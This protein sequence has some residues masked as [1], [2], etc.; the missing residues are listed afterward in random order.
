[1]EQ[2][3]LQ[4]L[5]Q[6]K[7]EA[8]AALKTASSKI[9]TA[10]DET[11]GKLNAFGDAVGTAFKVATGLVIAAGAAITAF[12]ISCI[13]SFGESQVAMA[14]VDATLK[15]MGASALKNRDAILK[16]ADAAVRLGFDDEDAAESIT[17]LYQRTGNLTQAMK[18]N[19]TAMDLARAKNIALS[20]ATALVGQVLSGNGRLLKQYGIEISDT[21]TPLEALKQLQAQVTGQSEAFAN[22]LQGKLG[23]LSISFSNLKEKIGEALYQLGVGG[24][25]D[26]AIKGLAKLQQIDFE[27]TFARWKKS[28][29]DF[30]TE[31]NK[32]FGI[33]DYFKEVW[34]SVVDFFNTY[35]KPSWDML[36][37]TVRENKD[38][39]LELLSYFI[40]YLAVIGGAALI[41]AL[42]VLATLFVVLAKAIEGVKW[43]V[44]SLADAFIDLNNWLDKTMAKL[45]SFIK[46][47]GGG[48]LSG[49]AGFASNVLG[50]AKSV[51]GIN[52]GIVQNGQIITTH[53]DDYLIA[54]KNPGSLMGGGGIVI[55]ITGGNF[56]GEPEELA[57]FIGDKMIQQFTRINKL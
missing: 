12:G 19:Q 46:K 45:D 11:R 39:L 2:S 13:K 57:K 54:T 41:G 22:T 29:T 49:V 6:L 32:Q 21:L 5:L 30:F 33:V 10:F 38:L 52:D 31:F 53:P 47:A 37:D 43:F 3:T 42:T 1:M 23:I 14:R 16:A 40:K 35:L 50:G 28:V 4:I 55:N 18:L 27:T 25:L 8:S 36:A 34:A 26:I 17:K 15:S 7:D 24:L 20:E 51:L 9:G 56:L 48:V 44:N